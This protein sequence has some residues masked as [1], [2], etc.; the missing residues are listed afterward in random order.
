MIDGPGLGVQVEPVGTREMVAGTQAL[1]EVVSEGRLVH[2]HDDE[3]AVQVGQARV[4][5]SEAGPVLSQLK[6]KQSVEGLR[7]VAWAVE[8]ALRAVPTQ[9]KP[10]VW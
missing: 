4:K 7:A 9:P 5:M 2:E 10:A 6:S 3:L 1:M 8:R